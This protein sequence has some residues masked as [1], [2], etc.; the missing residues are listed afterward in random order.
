MLYLGIWYSICIPH[1]KCKR[2]CTPVRSILSK[3]VETVRLLAAVKF[4]FTS[5]SV[6]KRFVELKCS[7][8]H[9]ISNGMNICEHIWL[10]NLPLNSLTSKNLKKIK[11]AKLNT[12]KFLARILA[13]V[14]FIYLIANS[15]QYTN[16]KP[17]SDK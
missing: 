12:Y 6:S 17:D 3:E 1:A 5:M 2:W 4:G 13:V 10:R 14:L 16:P 15:V 7:F 11:Y 9:L 8:L